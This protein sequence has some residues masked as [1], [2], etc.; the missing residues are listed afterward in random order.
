MTAFP[1]VVLKPGRE[2]SVRQRHPWVFSGAIASIEGRP[3]PGE[4]VEVVDAAG[5][6][7]AR[8]A[9]SPRSQI[10][11][12]L[13]TWEADEAIDRDFL[14]RRLERAL[15]GR[16]RLERDPATTAYRLVYAESDGLPGVI[17]DRYGPYLVLQLLSWGAEVWREDLVALLAERC[18]PRGIYERSEAAVRRLEG[19]PPRQ[20][21]LLWGEEPPERVE[22]WEGGR[23]FGVDI[24]RGQKT[25]AYLDQRENRLRVAPLCAGK[26]VLDVFTYSG[27]FAV[28]AASGG[29]ASVVGLDSSAEAL[30]LARENARRNGV[31]ERTWWEEGDAFAALREWRAAGRSFD[32]VI[33]DPPKFAARTSQVTA[34]TRGYKDINM[35]GMHLLR[36]GGLLVTFSCS[37]LVSAEL[38]QKVVFG[39]ALDAGREVQ[40]LA[41]LFQGED[42]PVRLTFPEG[43]YLK[44]FLCR[45]W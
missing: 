6:F 22:V 36:P 13:C 1:K 28:H 21:G 7:L 12:R 3:S 40:I 27:W 17:V 2:K 10:R 37:G 16:A 14:G 32:V 11:V 26:E 44:G 39:A 15:A 42:H 45:V 23:P 25:G 4:V 34:A 8:G 9:Y 18:V 38:F 35:L 31:A 24:R 5:R 29:A 43:A 19:L 30:E 20:S 33:L 41:R